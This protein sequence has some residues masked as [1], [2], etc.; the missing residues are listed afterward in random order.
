MDN[1][2][3]GT[4]YFA[5]VTQAALFEHELKGQLSDG[6]WENAAPHDHWKFWCDLEVRVA[7]PGERPRVVTPCSWRCKKKGYNFAS[8]YEV[9]G[10][11][12]LAIGRMARALGG[13]DLPFETFSHGEMRGAAEYMP[14]TLGEW[15]D[16][17]AGRLPWQYDFVAGYMA[18]VTEH[19]A[20]AFYNTRYDMRDLRADISAIKS[21]M[22]DITNV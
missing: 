3:T 22:K 6:M 13:S 19:V 20:R 4:V 12:L 21:T 2:G 14:T 11:R 17:K 5:S 1:K 8:L 16:C 9:I 15:L 10:D 7:P 18:H